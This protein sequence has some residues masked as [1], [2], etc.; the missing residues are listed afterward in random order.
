M[1]DS[2]LVFIVIHGNRTR[3]VPLD[4]LETIQMD[5]FANLLQLVVQIVILSV[6]HEWIDSFRLSI[7]THFECDE[8]VEGPAFHLQGGRTFRNVQAR[9]FP[10]DLETLVSPIHPGINE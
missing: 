4:I 5:G 7:G 1:P 9:A 10:D 3:I 8:R 6:P 2:S